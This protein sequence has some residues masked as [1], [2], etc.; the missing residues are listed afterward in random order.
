[1]ELV[2]NAKNGFNRILCAKRFLSIIFLIVLCAFSIA[3]KEIKPEMIEK[4]LKYHFS[5][6]HTP[7]I[8]K[9]YEAS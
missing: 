8:N 2:M 6:L 5:I 1:M 3:M 9:S 4:D 7:T